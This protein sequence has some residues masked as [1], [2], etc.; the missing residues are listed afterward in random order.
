MDS[1]SRQADFIGA[2]A[3]VLAVLS[4]LA[5][6]FAVGTVAFQP[7]SGTAQLDQSGSAAPEALPAPQTGNSS[8]QVNPK[9]DQAPPANPQAPAAE[10]QHPDEVTPPATLGRAAPG[11]GQ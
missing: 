7:V 4:I 3:L 2:L 1:A 6:A 8:A 11:A 9:A 10:G 5:A